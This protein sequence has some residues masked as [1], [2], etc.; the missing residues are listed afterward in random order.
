MN[1]T[2]H[3]YALLCIAT[4]AAPPPV[5]TFAGPTFHA[6]LT[7]DGA[8]NVILTIQGS[9]RIFD[10]IADFSVYGPSYYEHP[11]LGKIHYGVNNTTDECLPEI[12]RTC[13]GKFVHITGHSKGG[14]EAELLAA[15]LVIAG[16]TVDEVVTFGAPRWVAKGNIKAS[17][18]MN[19]IRGCGY[20]HFKDIVTQVPFIWWSHPEQRAPIEIGTGKWWQRFALGWLHHIQS[21]IDNL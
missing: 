7:D 17:R 9:D 6:I 16:I 15:K 4:Y 18:W 13:E 14:A 10:W 12:I 1:R 11:E 3:D 19:G 8:G 2:P 5:W 21:Y 20:R